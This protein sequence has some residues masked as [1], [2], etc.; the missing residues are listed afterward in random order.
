LGTLP[1]AFVITILVPA[2]ADWNVSGMES[3]RVVPDIELVS[4]GEFT[5][6]K[7]LERTCGD[8][9][10]V[11]IHPPERLLSVIVWLEWV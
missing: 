10:G 5:E 4:W 11:E 1:T 8:A 3:V 2:K 7:A 9:I 6:H